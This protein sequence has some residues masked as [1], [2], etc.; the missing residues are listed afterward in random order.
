MK[1]M[2]KRIQ[3]CTKNIGS[4]SLFDKVK[5]KTYCY[6]VQLTEERTHTSK[7]GKTNISLSSKRNLSLISVPITC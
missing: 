7:S 4:F 1:T 6:V 3:G 2:G 5:N